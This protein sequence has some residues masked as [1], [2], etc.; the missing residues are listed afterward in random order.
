MKI[1]GTDIVWCKDFDGRK[2]YSMTISSKGQDGER[3][4]AY[5][6]VRFRKSDTPPENG[7][8]INYTAFATVSKGKDKNYVVWQITDFSIAEDVTARPTENNFTAL[9]TDDI[10]F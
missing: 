10:P 6:R 1:E 3:I 4:R 7:T 5:Q 9:T 8:K 2:V